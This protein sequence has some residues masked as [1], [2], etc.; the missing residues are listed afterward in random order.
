V[1]QEYTVGPAGFRALCARKSG[2]FLETGSL[3]PPLAAHRLF[4]LL[5]FPAH[6]FPFRCGNLYWRR[7]ARFP[8]LGYLRAK[9]RLAAVALRNAPAGA[10]PRTPFTRK[11]YAASVK[12]HSR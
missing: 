1:G 8:F 12:R 11:W 9:S 6:T 3:S 5:G 10:V 2:A 7:I 4:P